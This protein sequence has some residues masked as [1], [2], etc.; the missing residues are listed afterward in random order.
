MFGQGSFVSLPGAGGQVR[1]AQAPVYS[2]PSAP[3]PAAA[4]PPPPMVAPAPAP[5][6]APTP[7]PVVS[8]GL[9]HGAQVAIGATIFGLAILGAIFLTD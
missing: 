9:S 1:L 6:P 5:A 3:M 7:A 4:P 8:T 2:G